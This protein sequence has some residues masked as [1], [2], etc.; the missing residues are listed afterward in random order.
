MNVADD[1]CALDGQMVEVMPFGSRVSYARRVVGE[2]TTQEQPFHWLGTPWSPIAGEVPDLVLPTSGVSLQ[3]GQST[4]VLGPF[5]LEACPYCGGALRYIPEFALVYQDW[6]RG[7]A[8]QCDRCD[9][10][11][12]VWTKGNRYVGYTR[13][14]VWEAAVCDF[15]YEVAGPPVTEVRRHIASG[16]KDLRDLTPTT[17]ERL[18]T[19]AFREARGCAA[20]HVGQS[21]DGGVDVL[22]VDDDPPL[23]IQVKRRSNGRIEGPAVVRELVGALAYRGWRRGAIVT[24]AESF[25]EMAQS[26]A[27]AAP[28][29]REGYELDLYA[30]DAL[31]DIVRAGSPPPRPWLDL[32]FDHYLSD[33]DKREAAHR[34]ES[35]EGWQGQIQGGARRIAR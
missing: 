28:L 16:R 34:R 33:E 19:A 25:S 30:Y 24:T 13:N 11:V 9:W 2:A 22:V 20:R 7:D 32:I 8:V 23:A 26:T 5:P 12:Y 17:L 3:L 10:W 14:V 18:V 4:G 1:G 27:T 6:R 21:R 35:R 29:Q 31:R 15:D